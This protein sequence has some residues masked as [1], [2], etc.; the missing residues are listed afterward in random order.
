MRIASRAQIGAAACLV[1]CVGGVGESDETQ[2]SDVDAAAVLAPDACDFGD[3]DE[4][5][6]PGHP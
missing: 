3:P 2:E 5:V 6:F 4:E 1:G